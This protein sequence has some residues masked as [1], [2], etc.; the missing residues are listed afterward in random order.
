DP[1]AV[2]LATGSVSLRGFAPRPNETLVVGQLVDAPVRVA[3]TGAEA[4]VVDAAVEQVL[5]RDWIVGRLA[6]R[7]RRH[8][9]ARR[10]GPGQLLSWSAVTGLR[11][12]DRQSTAGLLS[13]FE[14][15]RAADV[16]ATLSEL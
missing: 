2:T 15:L 16:A 9:L 13:V 12:T 11:L 7:A 4:V 10:R 5:S 1:G 6:I 8:S 3:E 14:T